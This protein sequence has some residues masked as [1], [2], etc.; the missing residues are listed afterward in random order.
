MTNQERIT[1][2]V[3][4]LV[5]SLIIGSG[6]FLGRADFSSSREAAFE[7]GA[8]KS[9][10]SEVS[11]KPFDPAELGWELV[12]A[13]SSWPARDSHAA[14][15]FNGKMWLVGGLNGNNLSF[16]NGQVPYADAEYFNDIWYSEDGST[17]IEALRRA[18]WHPERSQQL[19]VFQGKM[20]LIG[21]WGP[22]GGYAKEIWASED[23]IHWN[24]IIPEGGIPELEGH[25]LI[26]FHDRLWLFGGVRYSD[27]TLVNEIWSS[28]DGIRWE[29]AV[30]SAPWHPRWDYALAEFKGFLW[31]TG[32]MDLA[33]NEF[34]DIW[35]SE[36]GIQ[37]ERVSGEA[38][39]A[40]RQGHAALVYKDRLWLVGRFDDSIDGGVNDVWFTEDGI[41]WQKTKFDPVWR[42]REDHKVLLFNDRLWL[43]G[44]MTS[45]WRW[46][47]EVWRSR[48]PE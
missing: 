23:G 48:F 34:N 9:Q 36:D 30:K 21:G 16:S 12:A 31:L 7:L 10:E 46:S 44:G 42:G 32:G 39:W 40:P 13:S 1:V 8:I 2:L 3:S 20:W 5:L 35:R 17:W 38:P 28:E 11:V 29:R 26:V 24:F 41:S 27:R 19:A 37:W 33:G 47:N 18:P 4:V 6:R 14:A 22:E 43:F 15:V 25:E 45:D